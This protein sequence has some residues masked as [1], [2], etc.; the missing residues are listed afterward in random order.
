[1]DLL[2]DK[3]YRNSTKVYKLSDFL[4]HYRIDINDLAAEA[5]PIKRDVAQRWLEN[6]KVQVQLDPVKREVSVVELKQVLV[7]LK[8]DQFHFIQADDLDRGGNQ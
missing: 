7:K 8:F 5:A 1:M 4:K 2:R 3:H 6:D